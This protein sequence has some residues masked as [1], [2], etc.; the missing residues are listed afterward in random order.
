MT[1]TS[2]TCKTI[3][4]YITR[5]HILP[6]SLSSAN[7]SKITHCDVLVKDLIFK[8]VDQLYSK[9]I[10]FWFEAY[11]NNTFIHAATCWAN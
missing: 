1:P 6:I 2:F 3:R 11:F 10:A 5:L 9:T 4:N 8:L 7:M